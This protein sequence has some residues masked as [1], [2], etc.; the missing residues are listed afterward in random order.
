LSY[1]EVVALL[2]RVIRDHDVVGID[3]VELCPN[4]AAK[5]SDFLAAKLLYQFLTDLYASKQP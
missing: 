2:R 4:P 5:A 3:I 1:R